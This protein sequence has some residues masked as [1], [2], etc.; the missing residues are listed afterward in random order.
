LHYAVPGLLALEL[1]LE[2]LSINGVASSRGDA[3]DGAVSSGRKEVLVIAEQRI[4]PKETE[5]V[6]TSDVVVN[7]VNSRL[8]LSFSCTVQNEH[9]DTTFLGNAVGHSRDTLERALNT[10]VD[11]LHRTGAEL[12]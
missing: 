9:A 5:N 12:D 10:I 6:T 2:D 11:G 4:L 7:L 1:A 8:E 3:G